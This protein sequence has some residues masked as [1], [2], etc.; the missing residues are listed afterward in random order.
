MNNTKHNSLNLAQKYARIF[1]RG[2]YL[3]FKA[4]IFPGA[5]LSENRS[6][7]GTENV[8]GKISEYIFAPNGDY[9]LYNFSLESSNSLPPVAKRKQCKKES[10]N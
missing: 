6:L 10:H 2:H 8:R 1:V 9:R 4:R 3:F 7:L 5:T